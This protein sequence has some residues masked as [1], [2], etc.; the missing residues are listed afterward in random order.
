MS[1]IAASA[2]S[3]TF[4]FQLYVNRNRAASEQLLKEAEKNGIKAVFVTVDAPV[5]GKREADERVENDNTDASLT[6]APMS[7]A[8]ASNDSKGAGIGRTMGSYIDASLNWSDLAWLRNATKLP[9]VLKGIGSAEDAL[10]AASYGVDG[11]V[12][13]NHGGRSLDT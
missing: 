12:V 3:T 10:L 7:G 4:F 6:F 2:P 13:S 11:I 8:I 9:I 1:E 5:A